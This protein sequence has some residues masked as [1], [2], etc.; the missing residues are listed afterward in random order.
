MH[1]FLGYAE[2]SYRKMEQA[3][4]SVFGK[5]VRIKEGMEVILSPSSWG[6]G[7]FLSPGAN[8]LKEDWDKNPQIVPKTLSHLV[9]SC[10]LVSLLLPKGK[11][12]GF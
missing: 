8:N 9:H 5:G 7:G 1:V 3:L 11:T 6:L 10:G 4:I 2:F 12:C